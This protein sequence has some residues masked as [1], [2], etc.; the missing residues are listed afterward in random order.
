MSEVQ[1][2]IWEYTR[3]YSRQMEKFDSIVWVIH[4]AIVNDAT[5]GKIVMVL[6]VV[7]RNPMI[8]MWR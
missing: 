6:C 3:E 4:V 2:A 1:Y 5:L 7:M 8:Q